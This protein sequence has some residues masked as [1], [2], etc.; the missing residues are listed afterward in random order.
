MHFDPVCG[1]RM[2][3]NRAYTKIKY[4]GEVYYLCC[5]LCQSTFEK[6]PENYISD[7]HRNKKRKK[8]H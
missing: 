4:E 8:G 2:N 1:R 3:P 5:P 6:D 7:D